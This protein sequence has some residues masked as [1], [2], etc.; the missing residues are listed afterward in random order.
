MELTPPTTPSNKAETGDGVMDARYN[1]IIDCAE[2][3]R[4]STVA[5]YERGVA[6]I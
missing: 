3:N 5:G 4:I 1:Y 2:P 6:P